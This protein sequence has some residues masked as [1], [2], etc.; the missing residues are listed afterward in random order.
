MI[1]L[2]ATRREAAAVLRGAGALILTRGHER[3]PAH[4]WHWDPLPHHALDIANAMSLTRFGVYARGGWIGKHWRCQDRPYGL[5]HDRLL[6]YLMDHHHSDVCGWNAAVPRGRDVVAALFGVAEDVHPG[7]NPLIPGRAPVAARVD[8]WL[9]W[10]E[11][12][13][14]A[15]DLRPPGLVVDD[16]APVAAPDVVALAPGGVTWE[17]VVRDERRLEALYRSPAGAGA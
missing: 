17:D 8:A 16:P 4:A 7:D 10:V 12:R 11:D 13:I 14:E 1:A 6:R 5:A 2:T 15:G 9:R 3:T